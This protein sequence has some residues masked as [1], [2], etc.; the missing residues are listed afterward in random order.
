METILVIWV[1]FH[2]IGNVAQDALWTIRGEDPPSYRRQMAR[3]QARQEAKKT[4]G[5]GVSEPPRRLVR[6]A[7]DD[8][9]SDL[10]ERR[11]RR[12]DKRAERRHDRWE[13]QDTEHRRPDDAEL[14][15]PKGSEPDVAPMDVADPLKPAGRAEPGRRPGTPGS[16]APAGPVPDEPTPSRNAGP[17]AAGACPV[18]DEPPGGPAEGAYKEVSDPVERWEDISARRTWRAVKEH[19]ASYQRYAMRRR[20]GG[21][22]PTAQQLADDLGIDLAEAGELQDRWDRRYQRETEGDEA[23][24][25]PSG[26]AGQD[27]TPTLPK[28]QTTAGDSSVDELRR[29]LDQAELKRRF[30][31]KYERAAQAEAVGDTIAAEFNRKEAEQAAAELGITTE[32]EVNEVLAA[33]GSSSPTTR[34][35][36]APAPTITTRSV[37][38]MENHMSASGETTSLQSALTYTTEMANSAGEGVASVETSLA[39]L[40]DGQVSGPALQHLAQAQ[41]AL[42]AAQAEFTAANAA[43]SQH[44]G[45]TEAYT[46]TP[47]AGRKEFVTSD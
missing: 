27:D 41:E 6:N 46:A 36:T 35:A 43:L 22:A 25:T 39:S 10:D 16:R 18:P 3:W 45:V 20:N 21:S 24:T 23:T 29:E 13:R 26:A 38:G 40:A 15:G 31:R 47:D 44:L 9:W 28:E 30:A 34:P 32:E 33:Y 19:E 12:H 5:P 42:A 1:L 37:N 2:F 11:A 4:R 7:W 17:A 8:A 14:S